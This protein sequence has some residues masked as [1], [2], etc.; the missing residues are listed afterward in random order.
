[1]TKDYHTAITTAK[2]LHRLTGQ[3]FSKDAID[4]LLTEAGWPAYYAIN[5]ETGRSNAQDRARQV[6][7]MKGAKT[8]KANTGMAL[9]VPKGPKAKAAKKAPAKKAPAKKAPAETP[10]RIEDVQGDPNLIA[11]VR[12]AKNR[13]LEAELRHYEALAAKYEA[14]AKAKAV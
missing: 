14:E 1:M 9:V 5:P 6:R 7:A 3:P 8:R 2:K 10:T 13:A 4:G 12:A 11:K